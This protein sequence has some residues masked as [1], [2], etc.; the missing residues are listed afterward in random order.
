MVFNATFNNISVIS[1]RQYYWWR[2]PEYPENTTDLP[3]VTDKLY[4]IMLFRVVVVW[5]FFYL[6]VITHVV[7]FST[8]IRW[9]FLKNQNGYGRYKCDIHVWNVKRFFKSNLFSPTA[10]ELS[11]YWYFKILILN[12]RVMEFYATF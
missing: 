5:G 7:K 10:A 11:I 4:H 9:K 2:K 12:H 1:W 6:A 3:Q 8:R